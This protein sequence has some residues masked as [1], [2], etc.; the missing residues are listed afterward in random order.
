MVRAA[1]NVRIGSKGDSDG[2]VGKKGGFHGRHSSTNPDTSTCVE[3][4]PTAARE[5]TCCYSCRRCIHRKR[6]LWDSLSSH[7]LSA[8]WRESMRCSRLAL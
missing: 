6:L 3:T 1:T 5:W 4:A 2:V 8:F 7:L